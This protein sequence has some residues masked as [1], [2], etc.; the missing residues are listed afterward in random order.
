MATHFKCSGGKAFG[1]ASSPRFFCR[2]LITS[3]CVNFLSVAENLTILDDCSI[4]PSDKHCRIDPKIPADWSIDATDKIPD[5]V[6]LAQRLDLSQA[7]TM[8]QGRSCLLL[9]LASLSNV[10]AHVCICV[11][12]CALSCTQHL[13][14]SAQ[15]HTKMKCCNAE[16]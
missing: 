8:L 1:V 7:F 14:S 11:C 3:S 6:A 15:V 5:M 10:L 12:V 4:L 2:N 9:S 16:T 13:V